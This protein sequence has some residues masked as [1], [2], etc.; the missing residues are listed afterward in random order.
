MASTTDVLPAA[1][2]SGASISI[3][4][5]GVFCGAQVTGVDLTK[6]MDAETVEAIRLAHAEHGVVVFPNQKISSED[7]MRF[8]RCFGEL[9]VHPFST[10]DQNRKELIIFDNKEGNPPLQTDVWHSDEMFRECPPMGTILCSKIM[11]ELGGDTAFANMAAVYEGLSDRMQ[12]YLSGLEAVNDF[13]PFKVSFARTKEGRESLRRYEELYPPVSHPVVR[14]HPLTKRKAIYVSPIFTLHIKGMAEDESRM[15]L[16]Y[17]YR[18]TLIH[19][20]HYRHRWQPDMVVFWD[21]RGVQHSALHDYYPN[22]RLLERVTIRGDRPIGD[23]PPADP[24][25]L[26]RYLM[27]SIAAF[28]GVRRKRENEL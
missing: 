8:G 1:S 14:V 6:R 17:L 19:E 3:K 10:N 7:L 13:L 4:K 26:R 11:P 2:K 28:E 15:L 16:D 20:Y 12:Q 25:E 18:R 21:N 22:R 9:S 23:A 27:P 5:L 24:S